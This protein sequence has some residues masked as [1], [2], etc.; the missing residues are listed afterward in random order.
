MSLAFS[1]GVELLSWHNSLPENI[2]PAREKCQEKGRTAVAQ[3]QLCTWSKGLHVYQC[4][5]SVQG[6]EGEKEQQ[7]QKIME[8]IQGKAQIGITLCTVLW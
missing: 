8:P 2:Y 7:K 4:P 1:L 6:G 5:K 3:L